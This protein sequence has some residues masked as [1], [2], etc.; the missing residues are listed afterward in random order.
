[1]VGKEPPCQR[2]L[3]NRQDPFVVAVIILLIQVRDKG[4]SID[5]EPI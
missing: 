5:R 3:D 1:M 4:T 2:E